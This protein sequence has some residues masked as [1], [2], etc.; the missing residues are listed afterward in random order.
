MPIQIYDTLSRAKRIFEPGDPARITLYVCGPTVY[1]YAHIG[2]ARPAVVFDVLFRLLREVYGAE[3]VLY[4]RNITDVDDKLI[5]RAQEEGVTPPDLAQ[6]Y[7]RAYS[8]DLAALNVLAPTVEPWATRHVPDMIRLIERLL[9]DDHAYVAPAGIYFHVASMA[10]YGRLSRRRPEDNAAGARVA[11]DD[12]K[13]D[14]A[15]FALWKFAKPGEPAESI[16]DSPWGPGRPGWHIE[17]SAMAAVHLGETIDIHGGGVDLQFPHHENEIAQSQCAHGVPLARYWMHNGFLD[18]E[19]EKM[20]KS[21]GNVRLIRELLARWPGEVLRLGLLSGHYRADLD[22]TGELLQQAKAT[23][24]RL[25]GALRRVWTAEGGV[26]VDTGVLDALSDDLNT[27]E[28]LA[29]LS[30]L[31]GEANAA[32]DRGDTAA[33]AQARA[34]LLAAGTALGLLQMAP[35]DWEQGGDSADRARIDALVAARL[36]ARKA[37]DFKEADRIRDELAAEGIEVMDGPEGS[38]WRRL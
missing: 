5:A 10:D 31:A 32:A 37:R 4:A 28:A 7:A 12:G 30:R 16:W 27:P 24:D 6:T 15:D 36:D 11:V 13:R 3:H 2:N 38:T 1:N 33:M 17:C 14:P 19:G 9:A 22:W 21:L 8:E 29:A 34:D 23:L 35:A 18:L 20:S 25:Y 26:P